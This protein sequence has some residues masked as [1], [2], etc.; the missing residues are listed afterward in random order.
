MS[1]SHTKT[2]VSGPNWPILEFRMK[3]CYHLGAN[4]VTVSFQKKRTTIVGPC[5]GGKS[6]ILRG[7][8]DIFRYFSGDHED[9]VIRSEFG[10]KGK[11][12]AYVLMHLREVGWIGYF[13]RPHTVA[14]ILKIVASQDLPDSNAEASHDRSIVD[15]ARAFFA[16]Y[17]FAYCP[18]DHG[19][20][21]PDRVSD[22]STGGN[23]RGV[24]VA[25]TPQK[26]GLPS[27]PG[28]HSSVASPSGLTE[29]TH[30]RLLGELFKKIT[31]LSM[32]ADEFANL[33]FGFENQPLFGLEGL[34]GG[35]MD[36]LLTLDAALNGK[37]SV[38]LLDE[39]G[40]NLG[41]F[42]RALLRQEL[43][44]VRGQLILVTH[45]IEMI[46]NFSNETIL[47]LTL[48]A[49]SAYRS[50]PTSTVRSCS[51]D[52]AYKS[53]KHLD[54][55]ITFC[56]WL[57]LPQNRCLWFA[58]AILLVEGESEPTCIEALLK[59]YK[60]N[61]NCYQ[62]LECAG[63]DD[64]LQ[65]WDLLSRF[66]AKMDIPVIALLDYDVLAESHGGHSAFCERTNLS[67]HSLFHLFAMPILPVA[68]LCELKWSL[69]DLSHKLKTP[70][71]SSPFTGIF[72]GI[73]NAEDWKD[74][75]EFDVLLKGQI[76]STLESEFL[77]SVEK[78]MA[79][80]QQL[81]DLKKGSKLTAEQELIVKVA[82]KLMRKLDKEPSSPRLYVH[83]DLKDMS[84]KLSSDKLLVDDGE[85]A[86]KKSQ[87][88]VD[89]CAFAVIK[90]F[91]LLLIHHCK[92]RGIEWSVFGYA[93]TCSAWTSKSN[94]F[95]EVYLKNDKDKQ[96]L[97]TVTRE[98][99]FCGSL[100]VQLNHLL[101]TRRT[102]GGYVWPRSVADIEGCFFCKN[103]GA[104]VKERTQEEVTLARETETF[105]TATIDRKKSKAAEG[106][107]LVASFRTARASSDALK[108][109]IKTERKWDFPRMVNRAEL[110]SKDPAARDAI[111]L[112]LKKLSGFDHLPND[113]I[114]NF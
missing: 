105:L 44:A 90:S 9:S 78:F 96:N 51:F 110:I 100:S 59:A 97:L 77:G 82:D 94:M 28:R 69:F 71:Q 39:P 61:G 40:Q 11:D 112:F 56:R 13:D 93:L 107:P 60:F 81:E 106:N 102:H 70:L 38:V 63:R 111:E 43:T 86:R 4:E 114:V 85:V 26:H 1:V 36:A 21:F 104:G 92:C 99:G 79:A 42:E 67:F 113:V 20:R 89:H 8:F 49:A 41:A 73:N 80:L 34:S 64:V 76:E 103:P 6:T 23:A 29:R 17:P 32:S 35:Q 47:R 7:I 72:M 91:L 108:E 5:G 15:K 22:P 53:I 24:E 2:A 84:V 68:R 55:D 75:Q 83:T 57:T 19:L 54:V 52:D 88:N 33:S 37:A 98:V 25:S 30:S 74:K 87:T 27:P 16:A 58:R 48:P 12:G 3:H 50:L 31:G 95:S 101:W 45:H 65:K 46:P 18:Q 10:M 109:T 62:V 14:G 66:F